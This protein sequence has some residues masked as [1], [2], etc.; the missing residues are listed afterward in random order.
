VEIVI[1]VARDTCSC[2]GILIISPSGNFVMLFEN[3]GNN[4]LP[5]SLKFAFEPKIGN[6]YQ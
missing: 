6:F 1:Q 2:Q 3:D 4:N 5:H